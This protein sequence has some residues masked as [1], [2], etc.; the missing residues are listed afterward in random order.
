MNYESSNKNQ[1]WVLMCLLLIQLFSI[2]GRS[3]TDTTSVSVLEKVCHWFQLE[4]GAWKCAPGDQGIKRKYGKSFSVTS[5]GF[6]VNLLGEKKWEK[7]SHSRKWIE[8]KMVQLC[9]CHHAH[10]LGKYIKNDIVDSKRSPPLFFFSV[11][12]NFLLSKP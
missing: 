11:M 8:N 4:G 7:E 1:S 5:E 2:T 6:K 12:L 9:E 3:G 10:F